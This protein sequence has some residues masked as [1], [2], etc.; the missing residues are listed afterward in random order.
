[1]VAAQ[2]TTTFAPETQGINA[3]AKSKDLTLMY[4]PELGKA[5]KELNVCHPAEACI[6]INQLAFWMQSGYGYCTKD[7]RKWIYNSYEDW[8]S[9]Q[10][11]S[12]SPWNFGKMVRELEALEIIE[13]DCYVRLKKHL[14]T[15]PPHW[16]PDLTSS[17]MTLDVKRLFELTGCFPHCLEKS[18]KPLLDA[19]IA[20]ATTRDCDRNDAKLQTQFPSIYKENSIS[21]QD[22]ETLNERKIK[23]KLKQEDD[24]DPWNDELPKDSHYVDQLEE[25]PSQQN[26]IIGDDLTSGR[27]EDPLQNFTKHQEVFINVQVEQEDDLDSWSDELP[28]NGNHAD[29]LK[30]KPVL[31]TNVTHKDHY[32]TVSGHGFE[33]N[34]QP[35]PKVKEKVKRIWEIA[36]GQP[37]SVFINWWA[38]RKYKPQGGKWEADARGNAYAEFYNHPDKTTVVIFPEFLQYMQQIAL[39][40]N[41]HLANGIKA[42]LPSCF[43]ARPESTDQ[44]VQQMMANIQELVDRGA[45]VALPTNYATPSCT[46]SMSFAAAESKEIKALPRIQSTALERAELEISEDEKLMEILKVKQIKWK[47][48]PVFRG[49]IEEWANNTPGIMMTDEGPVWNKR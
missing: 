23:S 16:H 48:I 17:W 40:C 8:T 45:Q 36:P 41:Q 18:P 32:R 29:E 24:F 15:K 1:M 44:N 43:V 4:T 47:N 22:R 42:I 2:M 33:K 10:L 5:M 6:F 34:V 13:K 35:M 28:M 39:N 11:T 46:Q 21:T 31:Q 49:A 12:L 25:T 37:Y 26:K 30:H 27:G 7:D 38:D 19:E 9:N 14:V 3:S 20:N